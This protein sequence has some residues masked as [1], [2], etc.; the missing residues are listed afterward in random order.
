MTSGLTGLMLG[1]FWEAVITF[2]RQGTSSKMWHPMFECR[3]RRNRAQL[4]LSVPCLRFPTA[5]LPSHLL[6]NGQD[7]VPGDIADRG[8]LALSSMFPWLLLDCWESAPSFLWHLARYHGVS[9]SPLSH[10]IIMFARCASL[11]RRGTFTSTKW[12]DSG[13]RYMFPMPESQEQIN[14]SLCNSVS[15]INAGVRYCGD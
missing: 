3:S 7:I 12:S 14:S 5:C 13:G 9:C 8:P 6:L 4:L 11:H 10:F 1:R 2:R 15:L